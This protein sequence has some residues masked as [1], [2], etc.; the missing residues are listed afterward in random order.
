MA[1][2]SSTPE[3]GNPRPADPR[4]V[5]LIPRDADCSRA[6]HGIL[7][8]LSADFPG[9]I[10]VDDLVF[11]MPYGPDRQVPVSCLSAQLTDATVELA[12]QWVRGF[13]RGFLVKSFGSTK[14]TL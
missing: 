2:V 13:C 6:R 4:V 12:F 7:F 1:S 9:V 5:G 10:T 14:S 8:G 3:S 11:G